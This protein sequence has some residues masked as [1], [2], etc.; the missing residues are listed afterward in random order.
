MRER[1][2]GSLRHLLV[3]LHCRWPPL[4]GGDL[5]RVH[6]VSP[7]DA[8]T[9][10]G[11]TNVLVWQGVAQPAELRIQTHKMSRLKG[12][13]VRPVPPSLRNIIA[14][15]LQQMPRAT[16]VSL[17]GVGHL[18]QEEAPEKSIAAVRDFLK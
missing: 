5:G 1:A 16:L 6:I 9:T 2:I 18:P 14:A 10:D 11:H 17:P 4:R 13:I 7:G 3:A 12:T 8:R 15:S